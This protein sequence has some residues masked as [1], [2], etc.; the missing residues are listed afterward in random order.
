M[1][2]C[3]PA[4]V[5]PVN[6][7][8]DVCRINLCNL[9]S[10]QVHFCWCC[11][12]DAYGSLL[13]DSHWQQQDKPDSDGS[14]VEPRKSD[15]AKIEKFRNLIRSLQDDKPA[16]QNNEEFEMEVTWEPGTNYFFL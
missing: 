7:E 8:E 9:V 5:T 3:F 2:Y 15:N 11:V 14:D 12:A 6:C 1:S 10:W 4:T 16:H 13:D